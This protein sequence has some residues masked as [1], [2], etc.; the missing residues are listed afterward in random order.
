V[1]DTQFTLPWGS[2]GFAVA[3]IF[4]IVLVTM[5]Y[6]SSKIKKENILDALKEENT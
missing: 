6:S 3:L 1:L 5:W 2:Y 4:I